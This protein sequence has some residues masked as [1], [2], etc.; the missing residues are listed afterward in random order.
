MIF[1]LP[2][3]FQ[4]QSTI[5]PINQPTMRTS[6][7]LFA[8]SF[9][10]LLSCQ[11]GKKQNHGPIV[12]GDSS[13]I[14][15][16]TDP[17]YLEDMVADL[18]PA[19][20]VTVPQE[21]TPPPAAADTTPQ[22]AA[23]P[24][25]PSGEKGFTMAFKEVSLFIPGIETHEYRK[26]DLSRANSATYE[27]RGGK[28][29]GNEMLVREET[30]TKISQRYQTQLALEKGGKRLVLESLGKYLS[31]WQAIGTSGTKFPLKGLEPGQLDYKKVSAA[32][33]LSAVR[34]AARAQRL[35]RAETAEWEKL[36][37]SYKSNQRSPA[38]VELTAVMW[39]V[40]GKGFSKEIRMDVP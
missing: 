6:L 17:K 8:C 40:E 13:M 15:T 20:L 34:K 24:A 36:A 30:V 31:N 11:E 14:V 10:F 25:A 5:Q 27:L 22:P 1:A 12:L 4:N 7:A 37:R 26:Q 38:V 9:L 23:T 29:A 3:A 39:R 19:P 35:S 32:Q 18:Q 16:E 33:M 2:F 21:Q 28:L